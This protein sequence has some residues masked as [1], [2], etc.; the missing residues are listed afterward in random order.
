MSKTTT[1]SEVDKQQH[2]KA[3]ICASSCRSLLKNLADRD[4]TPAC[5]NKKLNTKLFYYFFFN[6]QQAQIYHS[7][8]A[9]NKK[10]IWWHN[11]YCTVFM[12]GKA[13]LFSNYVSHDASARFRDDQTERTS[14]PA[15]VTAELQT[16]GGTSESIDDLELKRR[17]FFFF[18]LNM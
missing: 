12:M 17:S 11:I 1:L 13:R 16:E 5:V 18:F 14:G 2:N 4:K 3:N 8:N 10:K 15:A 9:T 6:C 7:F